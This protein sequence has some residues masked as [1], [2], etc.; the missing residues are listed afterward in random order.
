MI[1]RQENITDTDV[2]ALKDSNANVSIKA[3][4]PITHFL[5]DASIN[6]PASFSDKTPVGK[7]TIY[8]DD[9]TIIPSED[10][11]LEN[12][13]IEYSLSPDIKPVIHSKTFMT[14]TTNHAFKNSDNFLR[15]NISPIIYKT[16]TPRRGDITTSTISDLTEDQT[17]IAAV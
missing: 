1:L 11:D 9:G 14:D 2:I 13:M 7:G 8:D 6:F 3:H 12:K 16:S 4:R 17:G 10:F 5:I 15:R